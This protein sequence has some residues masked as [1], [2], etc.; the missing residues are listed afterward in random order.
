[1]ADALSMKA[2]LETAN[3]II[4]IGAG[5][6]GLE[7]AAVAALKGKSVTMIEAANRVMARA[8]SPS[9]SVVHSSQDTRVWVSR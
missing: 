7:F 6:I 4:V 8:V 1:M 9:V 3:R 5:F 2:A